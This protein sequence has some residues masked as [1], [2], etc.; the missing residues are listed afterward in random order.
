MPLAA[1]LLGISGTI[2]S[3]YLTRT[4]GDFRFLIW[5]ALTLLLVILDLTA[6]SLSGLQQVLL[7][8]T[9]L[10]VLLVLYIA[11]KAARERAQLHRNHVEELQEARFESEAMR[12]LKTAFLANMNH[13]IRTPL[14]SIIGFSSLLVEEVALEH[15]DLIRVIERSGQRLLDT[16]DSILD[17]A[18]LEAGTMQL[19]REVLNVFE[20]AQVHAERFLPLAEAK[21]LAINVRASEREILAYLDRA[22]LSRILTRLIGNAVK[23]TEA[24]EVD[25]LI[26]RDDRHCEITVRDSGIGIDDAFLPNLFVDFSQASEGTRRAYEGAGLGLAVTKRLVTLL[27]GEIQVESEKGKGSTFTVMLPIEEAPAPVPSI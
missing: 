3:V 9:H 12:R 14:T 7:L 20:E 24:G 17:L 18:M 2:W 26:R 5:T 13:E 11:S 16:L 4:T 27:D 1:T 10:L 19:H 23:F 22:C 8:I 25:V 15:R 6:G 21:D